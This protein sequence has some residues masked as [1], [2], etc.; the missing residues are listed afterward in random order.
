MIRDSA[1]VV[2]V[3]FVGSLS[4]GLVRMHEVV[5]F[6]V[7]DIR[8]DVRCVCRLKIGRLSTHCTGPQ[9]PLPPSDTAMSCLN[10]KEEKCSQFVML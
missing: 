9:S 4:M 5:C 8:V 3:I 1:I 2:A 7:H 10:Q 6:I